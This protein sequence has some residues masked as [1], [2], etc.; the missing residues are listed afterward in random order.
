MSSYLT[1]FSDTHGNGEALRKLSGDFEVSNKI[2]FLGDGVSDL[3]CI[4]GEHQSKIVGV[5]GNC[6]FSSPYQKQAIFCIEE[7]AVLAV[8]GDEFG[9][10]LSLSR[11]ADYAKKLGVNLVL[12][13][14]THIPKITEINGITFVNPGSLS[15]HTSAQTFAFIKINGNKISANTILLNKRF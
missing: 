7:V 5:K 8:H 11:L 4:P 14:H 6:D 2:V 1:V 12:Y 3:Y 9:V 13:G 15:H 10:K